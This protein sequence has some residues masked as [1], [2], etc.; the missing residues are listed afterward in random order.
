MRVNHFGGLK[1]IQEYYS[2]MLIGC[3]EVGIEKE[4]EN[5]K[6]NY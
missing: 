6:K 1:K 2:E 5:Y 4:S 3:I